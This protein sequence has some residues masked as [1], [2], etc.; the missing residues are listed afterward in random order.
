ML[1]ITSPDTVGKDAIETGS[2][3]LVYPSHNEEGNDEKYVF[4]KG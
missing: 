3:F 4:P 2:N 1:L